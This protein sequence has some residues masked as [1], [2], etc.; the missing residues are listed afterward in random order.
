MLRTVRKLISS[1]YPEAISYNYSSYNFL[2]RPYS[3]KLGKKDWRKDAR[4]LFSS[5][6]ST[7]ITFKMCFQEDKG[8]LKY[9]Y[10][11]WI[12]VEYVWRGT[13][14]SNS[15]CM[16]SKSTPLVETVIFLFKIC[17]FSIFWQSWQYFAKRTYPFHVYSTLHINGG[18]RKWTRQKIRKVKRMLRKFVLSFSNQSTQLS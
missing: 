5:F 8:K 18:L 10:E 2:S 6:L 11:V 12:I 3:Y 17:R 16:Y 1:S 4:F 15:F 14:R 7:K 13:I 9:L